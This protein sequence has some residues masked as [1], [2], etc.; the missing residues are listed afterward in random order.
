M[1][2][3]RGVTGD[4]QISNTDLYHPIKSLYHEKEAALLIEKLRENL[5]KILS[6]SKDGIMK[7]CKAAFKETIAKVDVSNAFKRNGLKI[8]LNG[9][10]DQ[11][12][13]NKLK[14]LV[15]VDDPTRWGSSKIR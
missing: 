3:P 12:D 11:V 15:C 14:V 2:L 13:S 10:E 4:L 5:D 9:S 1:I 7:M 6:S 8:K